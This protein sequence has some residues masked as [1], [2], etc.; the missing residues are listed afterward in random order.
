MPYYKG[1]LDDI[2]S[3]GH[4]K[5]A[6]SAAERLLRLRTQLK[7]QIPARNV[8]ESI[9]VATWNIRE[10]GRNEKS[11]PRLPESFLFI[12][13]IISHF[14]LVAVQ[15]VNENL[16]DLKR[17]MKVLGDWWNYIVTDVT[18]GVSGNQERIAYVYDSRKVA[19]D[20]LAGELA[21]PPKL[22]GKGT[23]EQPA[24]SPFICSFRT[25]WRRISLCSVHIYYGKSTAN[26]S[27]RVQ[28]IDAIAGLLASRNVKRQ[29]EADGEPDSVILIGDF[30][31][32]NQS[33][34]ETTEALLRHD[35][36]I[37][38]PL[39]KL[40]GSNLTKDKY[41][42]QIAFH[43]PT[44]MLRTS[45]N[46]GVFDFM[47]TLFPDDGEQEHEE[48]M[49]RSC[50]ETYTKAANKKKFYKEWRTFQMSDHFPLWIELKTNFADAYLAS[51]MRGPRTKQKAK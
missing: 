22:R 13:E 1:L 31:I 47:T 37:P 23:S 51:V 35:F 2:K 39:R 26:D 16:S 4:A 11:G 40:S 7:H 19:F 49:M 33:G 30:N 29:L 21:I 48:A 36:V 46:A 27:R 24:R 3:A 50:P 42:D 9:L 12:A 15:E 32:F 45:Q 6:Q 34:D 43:D 25:G 20:H 10:F 41:F 5:S 44:K 28:E 38:S 18:S 17:L 8:T 14:D